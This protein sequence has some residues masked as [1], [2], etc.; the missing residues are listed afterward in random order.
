MAGRGYTIF[1]T[2]IGRCGIAWGELGVAGVQLP[3]LREIET[4]KRLFKLYPDAREMRPPEEIAVAI[5]GI[6]A[7]LRGGIEDLAGVALDMSGIPAFNARVYQFVRTI[8][9][10]ET[11]TYDEVASALRASGAV[12]SVAQA[13]GRN[14]FMIMVPCHRVLEAGNY[15]D[16]ISPNGGSISKRRLLSIEGAQPTTSKTL[17]DVLLPVARLRPQA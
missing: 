12:Y 8:P 10:G 5:E 1:D 7:T 17:F 2:A 15:A 4:R 13:L 3:E 16:R 6:A 9:R 14:P 11:R